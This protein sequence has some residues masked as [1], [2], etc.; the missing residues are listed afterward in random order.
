MRRD[1]SLSTSSMN[2]PR[3]PE[4]RRIPPCPQ[5][6]ATDAERVEA[7]APQSRLR[8]FR[9]RVCD[10]LWSIAPPTSSLQPRVS[11]VRSGAQEVPPHSDSFR[12]L[13]RGEYGTFSFGGLNRPGL[14]GLVEPIE[15]RLFSLQ[16]DV[17]IVLQHPA[18]EVPGNR[19]HHVIRLA[20]LEESGD[21]R[22]A[23]VGEA[24]LSRNSGQKKRARQDSNLRPPA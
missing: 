18:R 8:W 21:H 24:T 16:A 7:A 12:F 1:A 19:F 13:R 3:R 17:R 20:S 22:V 5:C 10:H 6:D 4:R 14:S 15:R 9:C 2:E 23:E 11:S